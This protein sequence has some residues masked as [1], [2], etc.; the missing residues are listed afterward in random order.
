MDLISRILDQKRPTK[1]T[2]SSKS[3]KKSVVQAVVEQTAQS[4]PIVKTVQAIQSLLEVS[5]NVSHL[6]AKASDAAEK[7]QRFIPEMQVMAQSFCDNAMVLGYFSSTATVVGIGAN[8]VQTYQGIQALQLIAA[9]L[10]GINAQLAAQTALIAQRD[11]PQYVYDMV[12]ERLN[13]TLDDAACEHWFFLFHPDNDWYPKFYHLLEAK[14][15]GRRFC[16]YTNQIDTIFVFMLAA[17]RQIE[18]DNERAREKGREVRRVKLHLLMPAYQPV[19]IAEALKIPEQIGDFVMEGR[20]NSNKPFFWLNLP[21]DQR[22]YAMDIGHWAP[23][24]VGW[25]E[26]AMLKVGVGE[27][28]PVLGEPRLLGTRQRKEGEE[29]YSECERSEEDTASQGNAD[30]DETETASVED[31]PSAP[32]D[33]EV[34]AEVEAENNRHNATPLQHRR[35]GHRKKSRHGDSKGEK[36]KRDKEKDKSRNSSSKSSKKSR[37]SRREKTSS[38]KE[39]D[40]DVPEKES[41]PEQKMVP[42][43][44]VAPNPNPW[45]D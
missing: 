3:A 11:F 13:Q 14:P 41:E 33:P 44:G 36:S 25:L 18:A 30:A 40:K 21:A 16:G 15:L 32:P 1:T 20:I 26:W 22:C 29:N 23:P 12:G 9:K 39:P 6:V 4:L 5:A 2:T 19:L 34:V 31:V 28:P 7:T 27:Q 42:D 38:T 17:R 10:E 24:T 43:E 45:I 37:E 35:K 8:L